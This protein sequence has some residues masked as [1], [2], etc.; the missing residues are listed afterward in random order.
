M[1]TLSVGHV[2]GFVFGGATNVPE[3]FKNS[4]VSDIVAECA[5]IEKTSV[6][7]NSR[8]RNP[9]SCRHYL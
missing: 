8:G 4:I 3:P 5:V 9:P 7:V 1:Q 2:K 6:K